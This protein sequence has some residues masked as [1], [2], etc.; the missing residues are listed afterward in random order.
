MAMA[1]ESPLPAPAL[2]L[3]VPPLREGLDADG[4]ANRRPLL[5]SAAKRC[6]GVCS[7]AEDELDMFAA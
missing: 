1:L 6:C 4:V 7:E 3:S 2:T 5:G